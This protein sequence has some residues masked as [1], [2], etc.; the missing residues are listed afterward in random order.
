VVVEAHPATGDVPAGVRL[1]DVVQQRREPQHQVRLGVRLLQLDRLLQHHQGVLVDILVLV[2]LVNLQ[3]HG[4][5]LGQHVR[6]E[7]GVHHQLDTGP[8]LDPAQQLR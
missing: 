3:A 1:A 5:D 4:G 8:R 6:G 7:P 2:V